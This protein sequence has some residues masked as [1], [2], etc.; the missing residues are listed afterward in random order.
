MVS[1]RGRI[2]RLPVGPIRDL[3]A[4][5]LESDSAGH[6]SANFPY[7]RAYPTI[8]GNSL[9]W[10]V[11]ESGP[12]LNDFEGLDSGTLERALGFPLKRPPNHPHYGVRDYAPDPDPDKV[13]RAWARPVR[14]FLQSRPS[15]TELDRVLEILFPLGMKL[16]P[17]ERLF[18]RRLR[19]VFKGAVHRP[20]R[21]ITDRIAEVIAA[22]AP[23]DE[24][25]ESYLPFSYIRRALR[26]D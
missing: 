20:G 1:L 11:R 4:A 14:A 26:R 10:L 23:T 16:R 8:P 5:L 22:A 18:E 7:S 9:A 17:H 6:G 21:S 25:G 2:R 12:A 15:E 24:A 19:R 13:M 3:V